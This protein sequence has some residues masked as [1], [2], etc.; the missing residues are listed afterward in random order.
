M[1]S[2]VLMERFQNDLPE[3]SQKFVFQQKHLSETKFILL[4]RTYDLFTRF[5][6]FFY[7]VSLF[8]V[9]DFILPYSN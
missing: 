1:Y 3:T 4:T 8:R 9:E 2:F 7:L 6:L 5:L